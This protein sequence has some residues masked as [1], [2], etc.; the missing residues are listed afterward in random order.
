MR[1]LSRIKKHQASEYNVK[2]YAFLNYS[3]SIPQEDLEEYLED[4]PGLVYEEVVEEANKKA[5]EI[6]EQA[7]EEAERLYAEAIKH[8]E[9]AYEIGYQ[10]GFEKG[11]K[12][13]YESI[14][15]EH[16][17]KLAKE[18]LMFQEDTAKFIE[19]MHQKK[20]QVLE[21]YID[22]LK[23]ISLAVAEKIIRTSLKSS[24]EIVKRM[25]ISA[26]DKLKRT[27][28]AK[29]YITKG[30][31]SRLVHGDASLIQELSHLSSN[32][33]IVVMDHEEDGNCIVELPDEIIDISINTQLQNIKDILNN[34]RL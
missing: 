8:Q 11:S 22:D 23:K 33:K 16:E 21:A 25:I 12:E 3:D 18:I 31:S 10:E 7:K 32:I 34:A 15:K 19:G 27:Q 29:I 26:T 28:W 4:Q 30:D 13:G 9:K 20:E 5:R 17:E 24:G 14:Y 2:P 1:S 6:V